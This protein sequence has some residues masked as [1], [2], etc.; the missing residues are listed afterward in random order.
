MPSFSKSTSLDPDGLANALGE[1]LVLSKTRDLLPEHELQH[2]LT[3]TPACSSGETRGG[4]R[5]LGSK[6]RHHEI[7]YVFPAFA[8]LPSGQAELALREPLDIENR[9]KPKHDRYMLEPQ[10]LIMTTRIETPAV[11][12]TTTSPDLRTAQTLFDALQLLCDFPG[13]S[14]LEAIR[15]QTTD[16]EI[17]YRFRLTS[18]LRLSQTPSAQYRQEFEEDEADLQCIFFYFEGN[19]HIQW[20]QDLRDLVE[21]ATDF[22]YLIVQQA[23]ERHNMLYATGLEQSL[24]SLWTSEAFATPG[25]IL[26]SA[27]QALKTSHDSDGIETTIYRLPC[28]HIDRL[29]SLDLHSKYVEQAVC[30]KYAC[31]ECR[32]PVLTDADVGKAFAFLR[33]NRAREEWRKTV[34]LYDLLMKNSYSSSRQNIRKSEF[35]SSLQKSFH[36]LLSLP[37]SVVSKSQNPACMREEVSVVFAALDSYFFAS[38]SGD[39]VEIS[40][41]ETV[42][43]LFQISISALS[44]YHGV[45]MTDGMDLVFGILQI[46]FRKFLMRWFMGAVGFALGEG[47]KRQKRETQAMYRDVVGAFGGLFC[48]RG[49][50]EEEEMMVDD[51]DMVS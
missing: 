12:M 33:E 4:Q 35:K 41:P 40:G 15:C 45:S 34:R 10:S 18:E 13:T 42:A 11:S 29:S 30:M 6:S 39:V 8:L 16:L 23:L 36:S 48:S 5:L 3:T 31:R 44:E 24:E 2:S 19:Y 43:L 9:E 47:E 25:E 32:V 27:M 14:T 49:Q 7:R 1:N 28:G 21:R 46:N 22:S 17:K 51:D 50:E 37:E 26:T 38:R 20:I